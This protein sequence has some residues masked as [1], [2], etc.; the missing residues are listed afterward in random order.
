MYILQP[1]SSSVVAKST[2]SPLFSLQTNY[3]M[4]HL[5]LATK[6]YDMINTGK[7]V[8]AINELYDDNVT[9]VE[10]NGDSFETKAKQ[11]ERL[12]EWEASLDTIHGGGVYA[13]TANEEQGVTIVE[14]WIDV[15]FKG[16][17][18][19]IKF[20]EIAVQN[21]KDGKIVRERF[22]YDTASMQQ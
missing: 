1:A 19:P 7:M 21:W 13:I 15:T 3:T 10:G 14:S 17:P 4:T 11:I 8:E 18:G 22:Y 12:G 2:F 5:E 16:A 20:E 6:L 9:I